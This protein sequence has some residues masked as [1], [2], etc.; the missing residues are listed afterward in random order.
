MLSHLCFL[1]WK[2]GSFTLKVKKKKSDAIILESYG[3]IFYLSA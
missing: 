2:N 3:N 1:Q